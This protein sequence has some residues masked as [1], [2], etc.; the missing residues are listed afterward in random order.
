MDRMSYDCVEDAQAV[1]WLKHLDTWG[2]FSRML[3]EP[4]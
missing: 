2:M 1:E 3:T 4:E